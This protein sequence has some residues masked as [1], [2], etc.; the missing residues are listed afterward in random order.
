M[1]WITAQREEL[2]GKGMLMILPPRA[3]RAQQQE[4][5]VLNDDTSSSLLSFISLGTA[6]FP[7][8]TQRIHHWGNGAVT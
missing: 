2:R 7:L 1:T 8:D 4:P 3:G 5:E 6:M